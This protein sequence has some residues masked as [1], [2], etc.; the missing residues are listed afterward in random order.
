MT[1]DQWLSVRVARKSAETADIVTL[2]LVD[3]DG[4]MLPEF[5][6]GAHIDVELPGGYIR[7]YS[8]C[9]SP[10][11]RHRYLIGVLNDRAGRGGSRSV[12]ENVR[13]TDIVRIGLP[14]NLFALAD[15]ASRSLLLAGGIGVTPILCMA[16]E[17][18][19]RGEDFAMHY[20]TRSVE[21]TAFRDRIRS[22]AYAERVQIHF[23]D[24]L[25]QQRLDMAALLSQPE[26]GTHLYVCGPNG[27]LD[28]VLNI[29]TACGWK[30]SH[31][32]FERFAAASADVGSETSFDVV[33]A[34]SGQTVRVPAGR[35]AVD[36]LADAGFVIPVACQQGAC[37]TCLTRVLHGEPD[38][39]D[40]FMTPEE[41][42][43]NDRFTPCCSRSKTDLLVLDL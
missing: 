41:H 19:R 36:T 27:F 4:G 28:A 20:C 9:N 34:S 31:I 15:D 2:E 23:D 22:S 3:P 10:Q 13:E 39:R 38:H 12:H 30:G 1:S 11:E 5:S 6:A 43:M 42:A 40:V 26:D 29:A 33:I 32:H 16:E 25:P 37:G 8:L 24:G 17:L 21:R 18:S 14:R 35:S 7:Q